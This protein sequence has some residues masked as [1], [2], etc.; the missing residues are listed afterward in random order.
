MAA[1][2]GSLRVQAV[3]FESVSGIE[4][5]IRGA[6][7]SIPPFVVGGGRRA[8]RQ[9]DEGLAAARDCLRAGALPNPLA[10]GLGAPPSHAVF[11][12]PRTASFIVSG[13]AYRVDQ[14]RSTAFAVHR[15]GLPHPVSDLKDYGSKSTPLYHLILNILL[16]MTRCILTAVRC[17]MIWKRSKS[18]VA[19]FQSTEALE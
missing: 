16:Q 2:S 15:P 5:V 6:S 10:R 13:T 8:A 19:L 4:F 12:V 17:A 9:A 14:G 11:E 7:A 1:I 18:G 3:D